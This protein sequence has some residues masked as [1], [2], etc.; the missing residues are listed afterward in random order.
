MSGKIKAKTLL[1]LI[2]ILGVA[3]FFRFYK[4][5]AIPPGFY[6]DIAINGNEAIQS[7]QDSRFKLFY[8]ENNGREGLM[9]WLIAKSFLL[10]GVSLL[11]IKITA[12]CIGLLT[13]LGLYLLAREMFE[14]NGEFIALLSSFFLAVSF[15]HVNFSRIGF[16]TILVPFVLVFAFYFF[17]RG[18]KTKRVYNLVL[19]G[20]FFG[21]G[22]YTYTGFRIAVLL[23]FAALFGW[24]L[25]YLKANLKIKYAKM[26]AIT[27]VAIFIVSLPIGVYFALNFQDFL[28]RAGQTSVFS[29]PNHLLA[30]GKS[31]ALHL[32]MFNFYGD[33]NWRHNY[34]GS[35]QLFWPVGFLFIAGLF[36]SFNRLFTL[37]KERDY[38]L[39]F[40]SYLLLIFWFFV[41]LMPGILTQEGIPHALRTLGVIPAI[42][43][44]SGIGGQI[45]YSWLSK[46]IKNKKVLAVAGWFFLFFVAG[47]EYYKYFV[48]W[49]N[50]KEVVGSFTQIFYDEAKLLSDFS[51]DRKTVVI[52]NEP[53]VPVPFP[54]GIPMPAQTIIFAE[55]A[56]C[57]EHE[58][59]G[60]DKCRL[61]YSQF[62]LPD[63]LNKITINQKA[64]IMPMKND[65]VIFDQ[66]AQI[67][68]SGKIKSQN[69]IT[70]Y[71]INQ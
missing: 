56:D 26:A 22:F 58:G 5:D 43:I 46:I 47:N 34:A 6:P 15:W 32:G 7:L 25:Y 9:I 65:Q 52:V 51:Y 8:P 39:E 49:S 45:V 63:Q 57:F 3:A 29:A 30:F 33:A 23:L 17:V 67:F 20:I 69:N 71:E 18:F 36:F 66:L 68:P 38:G 60:D 31:L 27:L 64:I 42:M 11:A 10:L 59:F 54:D 16:R 53:G 44:I 35:P 19:V 37:A 55:R 14:K 61:P 13:V 62:I 24:L 70:Y 2:I 1:F 12:A 48:L 21:A 4:L 28:G 41:M 50:N 40:N